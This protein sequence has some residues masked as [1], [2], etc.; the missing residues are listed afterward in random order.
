MFL[1]TLKLPLP[2]GLGD[3]LRREKD[4]AAGEF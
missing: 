4:K 3:G 1:F 2:P